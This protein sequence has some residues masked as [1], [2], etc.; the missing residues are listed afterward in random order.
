MRQLTDELIFYKEIFM[1]SSLYLVWEEE[2][3]DDV[4]VNVNGIILEGT[5]NGKSTAG[6]Y[7]FY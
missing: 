2:Q 1:N 5:V 7:E 4:R 3:S 6:V